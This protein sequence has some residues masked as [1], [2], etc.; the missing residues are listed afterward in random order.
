[1]ATSDTPDSPRPYT[2]LVLDATAVKVL[3]HPL[4]SRLLSTLRIDGP[5]TATA[6]AAKLSTNTG[7]TSYHLRRLAEVGLVTDTG[8]G[9]GKER[10]WRAATE[11]H[12]W[13][14]SAFG[15]DEDARTA[16]GWLVR[17]YHRR[18]DEAYAHW[19]DVADSWPAAW[20]DASGMSDTW[21]E[22]TAAQARELWDE[23]DAVLDRYLRAGAGDPEARRLHLYRFAFP[24]DAD[25][26]PAEPEA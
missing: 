10:I 7:A 26:P 15:E 23:I 16:L 21:V 22:V 3:A 8:E 14:N 13:A 4:R 17:G 1:M 5:A 12:G 11:S 6:L 19:L 20:Q 2:H 24:L 9:R 25:N 18:F